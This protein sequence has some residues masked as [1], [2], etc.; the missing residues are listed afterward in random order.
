MRYALI[1]MMTIFI[2]GCGN[3]AQEANSESQAHHA[4]RTSCVWKTMRWSI[5]ELDNKITYTVTC[6]RDR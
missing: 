2:V 1:L 4:M 5:V 6:E 3:G